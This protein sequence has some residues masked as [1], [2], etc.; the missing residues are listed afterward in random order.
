MVVGELCQQTILVTILYKKVSKKYLQAY[1]DEYAFR[2]NNRLL[3]G[4]MFDILLKQVAEVKMIKGGV[5][6]AI[7]NTS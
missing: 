1:V 2:Y 3:G 5:Q 4:G 6:N 7:T